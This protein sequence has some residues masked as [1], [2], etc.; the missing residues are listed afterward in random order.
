MSTDKTSV[1]EALR[2][3]PADFRM[4]GIDNM[5]E[6]RVTR[7]FLKNLD[8]DVTSTFLFNPAQLE[9]SY[10]ANY[11]RHASVGLSHKRLQFEGN[12][13]WAST[14]TLIFDQLVFDSRRGGDANSGPLPSSRP[15]RQ[16]KV[17]NDVD[18]WRRTLVS[19]LYPRR[20]R[21]LHQASPPP[22]LFFWPNMI[23]MRVRVVSATFR[24]TQFEVGIPSPR[25]MSAAV[26]LEEEAMDR[27]YSQDVLRAGMIRPWAASLLQRRGR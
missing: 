3:A 25:I 2:L 12:E 17:V 21:S 18:T 10:V 6:F 24:H 1:T 19:F 22:V 8:T 11:T 20:S 7:G 16:T 27:I 14:L 26:S 13:N 9:E 5:F 4:P 23:T 15:K